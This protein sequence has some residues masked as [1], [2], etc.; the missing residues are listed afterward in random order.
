MVPMVLIRVVT[1]TR[2]GRGVSKAE[3]NGVPI[4]PVTP[5][6]ETA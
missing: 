4:V 5:P 1:V 3:S 2:R 6:E